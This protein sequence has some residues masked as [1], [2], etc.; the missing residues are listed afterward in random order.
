MAN[1]LKNLFSK[2]KEGR[3]AGGI[4]R[5]P[6]VTRKIEKGKGTEWDRFHEKSRADIITKSRINSLLEYQKYEDLTNIC[7]SLNDVMQT[8]DDANK[9]GDKK[10]STGPTDLKNKIRRSSMFSVHKEY[11]GESDRLRKRGSPRRKRKKKLYSQG[12][13]KFVIYDFYTPVGILGNG[14]YGSV[15]AAINS[16][17]GKGVAIKKNKDVFRS[18]SVAKRILREIKLI[19]FF[20]HDD[21]V[22]IVNVIIPDQN[23]IET[24]KDVYLVLEKMEMNL[25]KVIRSVKLTNRHL[26]YLV[27]QMFRGLKYI[28]SAGVIHRDLKP[29]N[30]LV[31]A[32]DCNLKIT[33]FGLARGVC[34]EEESELTE[35]VVTRWYRAPEVMCSAKYYDAKV[36]VWSVGCILAEMFLRKPLFPGGNHLEQLRIIFEVLGTPAN[37]NE[38]WIK[39][40]EAKEW[41]EL[42]KPRKGYSLQKIFHQATP[43]ALDLLT[44]MLQ[45]NPKRRISVN[46]ALEH[47]YFSQ[48]HNPASEGTCEKFDISFEFEAKINSKFGVRH[49]MYEELRNFKK[50]YRALRARRRREEFKSEKVW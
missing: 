29:G 41:I 9:V 32:S 17:T 35:Y 30:I 1:V 36:D 31:N 34:K 13:E 44:D 26:Q 49:M 5:R 42:M 47:S 50:N 37:D 8:Q 16:R 46:D 4:V 18:L 21:I 43:D 12:G 27:Y 23:E 10:M 3:N 19:S 2:N 7:Q 14:G 38:T 20:D 24:F 45:L 40:P 22:K 39:T 11:E 28:H 15:C 25:D 48:L 33:D 6:R